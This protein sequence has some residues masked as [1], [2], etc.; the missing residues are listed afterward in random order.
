MII[1]LDGNGG[2]SLEWGRV[3]IGAFACIFGSFALFAPVRL[4]GIFQVLNRNT[5]GELLPTNDLER[6]AGSRWLRLQMQFGGAVALG[7][8]LM[9]LG[10]LRDTLGAF[11]A[12]LIYLGVCLCFMPSRAIA[13]F[14]WSGRIDKQMVAKYR[15]SLAIPGLASAAAGICVLVVRR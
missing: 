6:V 11:A 12:F 9:F 13:L 7:F 15:V 4:A 8:G 14:D 3:V 1:L 2:S 10:L 5:P